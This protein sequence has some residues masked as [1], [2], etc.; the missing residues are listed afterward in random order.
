MQLSF[1]ALD[2]CA[3]GPC[4]NGGVCIDGYNSFTCNC[5]SV[6]FGGLF[7]EQPPCNTT[8]CYSPS[9][10]QL[11]IGVIGNT[12]SYP[13]RIIGAASTL[14]TSASLSIQVFVP[15]TSSGDL[16]IT[17]TDPDNNSLDLTFLAGGLISNV[18]N[19]VIF[20]DNAQALV[21][22][23]AFNETFIT[24]LVPAG[25]LAAFRGQTLSGLWTLTVTDLIFQDS[26][27]LNQWGINID[28]KDHTFLNFFLFISFSFIL[29]FFSSSSDFCCCN[30][31]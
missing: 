28:C 17:L 11:E 27:Y 29:L 3:S 23:T 8:S 21:L 31:H 2:Q 4:Q 12:A 1:A 5:S 9:N 15:H 13:I 7:C 24:A 30:R 6:P 19:G 25:P 22:S 16:V 26:G 14:P 18:Y 10:L 20:Q